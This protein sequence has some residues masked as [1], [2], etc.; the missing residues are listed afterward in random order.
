MD[1]SAGNLL[2]LNNGVSRPA[3]GV[4]NVLA[5]LG[6]VAG[7]NG[8]VKDGNGYLAI[9]GLTYG[10]SLSGPILVNGGLLAS[11]T[12]TAFAGITGDITVAAGASFAANSGWNGF[13]FSNNFYLSGTGAMPGGLVNGNPTVPDHTIFYGEP[14]FGALEVDY[15][16]VL[17]G[18]ITLIADTL[19]A[20]GFNFA[21]INGPIGVTSAGQNLELAITW[22]GQA[23]L[24][25]NGNINLGSGTLTV[26]G[27]P[28]GACVALAGSNTFAGVVILSNGAACFN[29]TNAIGGGVSAITIQAGGTASLNGNDLNP[30][31][32]FVA[33]N[34]A[35]A[36]ALNAASSSTALNLS[37]YPSLAL[38]SIGNST[39]SGALTP[40]GANYQLGGGGG[41]L[42]VSSPLNNAGSGLVVGGNGS[43][44]TVVLAGAHNYGGTTMVGSG[45]L[46]VSGTLA[47][48]VV[49]QSGGS[50]TPGTVTG[51]GTLTVNNAVT[52]GGTTVFL[53]NR[54][55][56]Q[57]AD[58]LTAN[59][60]ILGGTL[61]VCNIG[62][63][64][65]VGDSFKLF[66]VS[67]V[68]SNELPA[69]SVP[70]LQGGAIW[71]VSSLSVDGTIK[72]ALLTN[73][74]GY[75]NWPTLLP[76]E[77]MSAYN[78]GFSNVTINPGTYVMAN[79]VNTAITLQNMQNFTV[80]ASNVLMTVGPGDCFDILNSTNVTIEGVT[81]R[82]QI[83]PFTQGRVTSIGTNNGT[84]YCDWHI[85]AG[86][87][88]TNFQWWFNAVSAGNRTINIQQGDI[89]Y[90]NDFGTNSSGV[91]S[92]AVY[93]GDQTW[94][95]NF[96]NWSDFSFQ[97]NDWLVARWSNQGYAYLLGYC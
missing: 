12:G 80:N 76:Q 32:P 79:G 83:Y 75:T 65:V 94:Q 74:V 31:L 24:I 93:L 58:L 49:V 68:F 41:T 56:A 22:A 67:G 13:N 61:V 62:P 92:N 37:A 43:G 60:L 36:I 38:G 95:L 82:S 25:A 8:F 72:V 15:N 26:T 97:T 5:L 44:G 64:L 3:I 20:H 70:S 89:P 10:N 54:T 27:V 9:Y 51:I 35:G 88:N 40:G 66:S 28:G 18:K 21:T 6:G 47:G 11:V 46:V 52:L 85:S 29:S 23:S 78:A 57:N 14:S 77:I 19:I 4:T 2:T 71:D 34:S 16:V 86:Y 42:T 39:Y 55:N 59:S 1:G 48:P 7:T 90:G 73:T 50:L 30:L 53:I 87:P 69:L 17:S 33:T 84:L 81:V 96:P 45:N 91:A 63:P